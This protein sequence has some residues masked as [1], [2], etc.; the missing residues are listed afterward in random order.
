MKKTKPLLLLALSCVFLI[1]GYTLYA[2]H[3]K[4]SFYNQTTNVVQENKRMQKQPEIQTILFVKKGCKYCEEVRPELQRIISNLSS[5]QRQ[6]LLVV[7]VAE[8]QSFAEANHIIKT[9]T[10]VSQFDGKQIQSYTGTDTHKFLQVLER[11]HL[12][13]NKVLLPEIPTR[14]L[15]VDDFMQTRTKIDPPYEMSK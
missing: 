2:Q 9:P 5:E 14:T 8:N 11:K 1:L 3:E 15:V 6:M 7:N 4:N 10:I 13:S 12:D